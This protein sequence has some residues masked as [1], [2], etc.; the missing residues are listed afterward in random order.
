[1]AIIDASW[2]YLCI[3]RSTGA[4]LWILDILTAN[5]AMRC[6]PVQTPLI[7]RRIFFFIGIFLNFIQKLLFNSVIKKHPMYIFAHLCYL[8]TCDCWLICLQ[9]QMAARFQWIY[10]W[11]TVSS[12]Q[13][14]RK[15]ELMNKL[16]NYYITAM[17]NLLRS[18]NIIVFFFFAFVITATPNDVR[19]YLAKRRAQLVNGGKLFNHTHADDVREI[20]SAN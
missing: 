11:L 17:T 8:H 9:L 14:R 6:C 3:V 2:P 4:S 13:L 15:F 7:S 12:E 20:M 1:M 19:R 16:D 18:I 5:M 10:L